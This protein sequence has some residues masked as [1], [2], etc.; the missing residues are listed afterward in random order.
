MAAKRAR[1]GSGQLIWAGNTWSVRFWS[2]QDG[3]RVRQC[4]SLE[5]D[6]RQIALAKAEKVV[7]SGDTAAA[8]APETFEQAARRLVPTQGIATGG[9]RM[10]RLE[11]FAF[12]AFGGLAVT[13]VRPTHIRAALEAALSTGRSR[14]TISHLKDDV[15][16]VFQGL[17]REETVPE[18]PADRVEVPSEAMDDDRPRVVLTDEEFATFVQAP[19]VADDLRLMALVSRCVG[20][21]RTSDLHAWDWGH[22]DLATWRDAYI[23]RPKTA[24]TDR[25]ALPEPVVAP[26]Q[27]WWIRRGRP[28]SG[29]VFVDGY[30][31]PWG[32][33]SH[34][35]RLRRQLWL[36]GVRRTSDPKT[37]PLQV[38][39]DRTR[40]VDFHSFRRQFCTA[41]ASANINSQLAMKLAGHRSHQ[42]H[43]R[44]VKLSEAVAL[45][46]GALPKG[47]GK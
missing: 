28:K 11:R 17:W 34:A 40:C 31:D 13:R 25:L 36:A 33:R 3:V 35:R 44:Y 45:P 27:A 26:L 24:T 7:R 15:S 47:L 4:V 1:K 16:T 8:K 14:T 18:N 21:M 46:D 37:C 9:E 23:P 42:T 19:E 10:S 39:T 12:P 6:N 30:G 22:I 38:D 43:M 29:P 41:I 32:K 20:G 5:T 2:V